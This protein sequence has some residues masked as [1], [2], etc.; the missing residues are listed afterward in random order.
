MS[1]DP[2]D[3]W[4]VAPGSRAE[5]PLYFQSGD[6]TLFGWLHLP[7]AARPAS[8]GLLIC[9]PFGFEALCSHRSVKAFAEA[10][11]TSGLPSLR[12]DYAGT[13][14]SSDVDAGAD[15]LD[16]WIRDIVS[17]VGELKRRT[18]VAEVYLLGIRLG[19]LL[20]TLAA[21]RGNV[22]VKGLILIVPPISGPRYLRE[23]RTAQLASTLALDHQEA[24]GR[25]QD[26]LA[27][28]A[29][30]SMEVSG[31]SMSAATVAALSRVDLLTV[32]APHVSDMLVMD[33]DDLPVA[34]AWT[35]SASR[36]GVRAQYLMLPGFVP[37]ALTAPQ[38]T[39]VPRGMIATLRG[40]LAL[41]AR[42]ASAD[43]AP[44]EQRVS[45]AP[46]AEQLAVLS[47]PG[48]LPSEPTPIE[49]PLQFGSEAALFGIVTEPRRGEIRR[50]AVILLNAGA[51]YH[52]GANRMYVSLARRLARRGYF[53][54]R[55]D[56]AGLGD[57]ETR[58]GRPDNEVFPP[59]AL[60]DIRAAMDLVRTR[61]GVLDITLAGLCSGAY[62]TL[63]A[64][65][66]GLP[67]TRILMVN[68]QNFFWK[69]GMKLEDLQLAEVVRNP[70]VYRARVLSRTAWGRLL[71]GQ[72]NVWRI[73]RIYVQRPLLALESAVRHCARFLHIRL[74]H[75]LGRELEEIAARGV[76]T[77]FIFSRSDAGID[78]LRIQGGSVL[79][80]LGDHC[81]VH[82]VDKADHT[83]SRS[84]PRLAV[85]EILCEE[86][87]RHHLS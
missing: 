38:F 69:E 81:R 8:V 3:E 44:A 83:L 57:S 34:R 16:L 6:H 5:V 68:P 66:A 62:H 27:L 60:D 43:C 17:A 63:R 86:L 50:R 59:A 28:E 53:V 37:M 4:Y 33:R 75:D 76:R 52:I 15:Q 49:R 87:A 22:A 64:A 45:S 78:L 70:G 24:A 54:L 77:V 10:A 84:R 42:T 61:Y 29:G 41:H 74:P 1:A 9:K 47:L 55:M 58:P 25:G 72:V 23:L 19:A 40:W 48:D 13:G 2:T 7:V 67:V 56:L 30:G 26:G 82:I 14:D 71:S 11:A 36:L 80:R 35:E 39:V 73:V 79:Q 21:V 46:P 32:G 20:A 65:A 12:F 51:S 31:Y 85:E 18:G